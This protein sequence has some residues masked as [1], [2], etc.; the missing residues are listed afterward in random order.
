MNLLDQIEL[1][2]LGFGRERIAQ[3][4]YWLFIY[5]SMKSG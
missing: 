3:K 5:N 2:I 1:Y 4:D